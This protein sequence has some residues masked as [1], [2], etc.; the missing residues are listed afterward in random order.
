MPRYHLVVG[1]GGI[2]RET[3]AA[4]VRRGHDVVLGSRR[5]ADPGIPGVTA[6]AL[7]ATDADALAAAA[8]GGAVSIVNA[9]NPASYVHW[10]RD[11]PPLAT[12]FL[13]AAERSGAGLLTVSNL[14]GYGRVAGPM[15]ESTPLSPNGIKGRVRTRVWEQAY[16]AHVAGRVRA[17]ELR[18]SDYIGAAAAPGVSYLGQYVIAPAGRGRT[19]W[20]PM[21]NPDVP[22]S[23]THLPDIGELAAVLATDRSWGRA[24]HVPTAAPPTIRELAA[25]AAALGGHPAPAVRRY[26]SGV[27]RLA[28]VMPLIRALDETRHQF[29][30]P[31][32][33]DS[34]L[35]QTTFGLRPTPWRDAVAATL[36]RPPGIPSVD[37]A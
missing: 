18:A 1:A 8:A 22:H 20:I 2:G 7:D 36:G 34:T 5:G 15:T 14:Y 27:M 33:L 13:V 9:T 35:A 11:W 24:W 4:L 10:D 26:P 21:G 31:F 37:P 25:Q 3:A 16:A 29:E 23:V 32:V 6:V 19:A 30:G 17:T 28:R 12:A